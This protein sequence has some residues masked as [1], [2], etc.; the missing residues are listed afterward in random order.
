MFSFPT[1]VYLIT[2]AQAM[3]MLTAPLVIFV[4]GFIGLSLA[5][6]ASMAT[7]PVAALIVGVALAGMPAALIMQKI[8][9]RSG[10]VYATLIGLLGSILAIYSVR[11]ELFWGVCISILLLGMHLAFVYQFFPRKH[12]LQILL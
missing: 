12:F 9:R 7:L 8:G 6:S 1:P 5:P 4:G 11:N 2:I 3:G 10:F